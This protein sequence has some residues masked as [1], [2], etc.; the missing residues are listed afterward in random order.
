MGTFPLVA[1]SYDP[2]PLQTDGE[3][4]DVPSNLSTWGNINEAYASHF[5]SSDSRPGVWFEQWNEPDLSSGGN[6]V[7]FNGNQTDDGNVYLNGANGV[8]SGEANLGEL[9]IPDADYN[10][11]KSSS[12]Q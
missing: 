3:F 6:K 4:Q 11:D 7:F 9:P 12:P 8:N 2:L 1:F 10:I 5:R